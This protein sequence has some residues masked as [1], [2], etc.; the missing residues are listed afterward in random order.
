MSRLVRVLAALVLCAA[1]AT[2]GSEGTSFFLRVEG[3]DG[4]RQLQVQGLRGDEVL[5]GPELRPEQPADE[6]FSGEQTLRIRFNTL[7]DAPVRIEVDALDSEG[8]IVR[9][10]A[11]ATP[12]KDE[13]V[14]LRIELSPASVEPLPDGGTD[15]GVPDGGEP[16]AGQPDAGEPDGGAPDSGTPDAGEPDGGAPDSGTPDAGLPDAGST[17]C[18]SANCNN[19]CCQTNRCVAPPSA[20]AC[21]RGGGECIDCGLKAD[22]CGANGAC[23][24]G[25][26]GTACGEGQRCVSGACECDP[27][28]CAGCCDEGICRPGTT[29][30]ACGISG[31]S[32]TACNTAKADRCTNGGCRCGSSAP[33]T[34]ILSCRSGNCSL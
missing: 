17:D 2:C 24:C 34:G 19:G 33:C 32:C 7:P 31:D 23:V 13:E 4:A 14:E 9:G 12:R 22:Q 27:A 8:R 1:V 30:A 11:E 28:T 5:F 6:P 16:D 15:G 26:L 25:S 21:G 3:A 20:S 10:S 29:T 18:S